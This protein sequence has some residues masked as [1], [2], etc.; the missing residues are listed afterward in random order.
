M[1]DAFNTEVVESYQQWTR[2]AIEET[3]ATVLTTFE[4]FLKE[5]PE[6]AFENERIQL[7]LRIDAVDHYEDHRLPNAPR[8]LKA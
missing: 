7:W 4:R 5:L 6:T 8:L 2:E 3:F 1:V